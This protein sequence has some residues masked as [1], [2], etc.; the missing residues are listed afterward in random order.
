MRGEI[1]VKYI[2]A[3]KNNVVYKQHIFPKRCL[4]RF[5]ADS[6]TISVKLLKQRKSIKLRPSNRLFCAPEKRTWSQKAEVIYGKITEDKFQEVVEGSLEN[7][8]YE[9]SESDSRKI[10]DFY[11]LWLNRCD[12]IDI[13]FESQNGDYTPSV[14]TKD[15]KEYYEKLA[16]DFADERGTLSARSMRSAF[17]IGGIMHFLDRYSD[18]RWFMSKSLHVEFVVPDNPGGKFFIPIS[19]NRCFVA[20]KSW[21][22]LSA[23][24]CRYANAAMIFGAKNYYCARDFSRCT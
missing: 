6:E 21:P 4:D 18:L 7:D 15:E 2:R 1:D 11:A 17:I 24:Q 14:T 16:I 3:M 5:C 12:S 22:I 20:E 9:M 23:D 13:D 19:P 8:C 10:T